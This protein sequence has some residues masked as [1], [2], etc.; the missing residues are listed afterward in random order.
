M[1]KPADIRGIIF[2]FD[3]VILDSVSLKTELFVRCY[4]DQPSEEQ[5]AH[6]REYQALHG[7]V[8]RGEKF[9]YFERTLFDREP[10]PES[11]A[12][13]S[14][15]YGE[16]L[17]AEIEACG[18]LPGALPFLTTLHGKIPLHLV[19]G[20]LH[21]DLVRIL[22]QRDLTRFFRSVIG[23][24]MRKIDAF[25][26]IVENEGYDPATILAIGDAITELEAAESAGTQFI[27]IVA[28]RDENLF[29]PG[30]T[31]YP[32]LASLHAEWPRLATPTV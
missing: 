23:S 31:I 7:G 5:K 11:V 22:E 24:P 9:T 25:R 21:E 28:P 4:G 10:T 27:G 20:T 2:D 26:S 16:F 18:Y 29:P 3:G 8:G 30:T 19:S 15:L 13:L 14:R 12:R 1:R 32:D 17:A 6:I